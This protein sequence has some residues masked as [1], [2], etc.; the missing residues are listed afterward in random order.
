MS[1][2]PIC[3][4]YSLR[5]TRLCERTL[6]S[7]GHRLDHPNVLLWQWCYCASLP[8]FLGC[9]MLRDKGGGG[10]IDCFASCRISLVCSACR[11]WMEN[12]QHKLWHGTG[13]VFRAYI[14]GMG[15]VMCAAVVF[16][17]TTMCA[18]R[19]LYLWW[20][21]LPHTP[22]DVCM[23]KKAHWRSAMLS[24]D[25]YKDD[26]TSVEFACLHECMWCYSRPWCSVY[27][28]MIELL[29]YTLYDIVWH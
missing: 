18:G 1:P 6:L 4:K 28:H 9:K 22:P 11:W 12:Q 21:F 7:N 2:S 24:I 27:R 3:W 13:D 14:H 29:E 20:V 19:V 23:R 5:S 25:M 16:S 10:R 8:P 26:S 15:H 17:I